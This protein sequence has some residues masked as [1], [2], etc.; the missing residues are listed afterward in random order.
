L[1]HATLVDICEF[2]PTRALATQMMTEAR[3][4][5][6]RLGVPF[7]VSLEQRLAG[8]AAV[9]KH[10]TSMLQDVEAGRPMELNALV[11]AVLDLGVLDLGVIVDVPTPGISAVHALA[12]M[13]AQT[14]QEQQGR[15]AI[16]R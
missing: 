4:I 14:L 6:E 7:K 2:G 15:L 8:A 1:T 13:L 11:A 5:G 10:K 16:S 12:S 9:G 3:T